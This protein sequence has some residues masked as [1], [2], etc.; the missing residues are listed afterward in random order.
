MTREEAEKLVSQL[1]YEQKL[2]LNEFLKQI[3]KNRETEKKQN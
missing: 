1:T 3:E 2:A